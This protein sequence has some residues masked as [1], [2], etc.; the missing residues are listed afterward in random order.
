V[1]AWW[2]RLTAKKRAQ[3]NSLEV[4]EQPKDAWILW[5]DTAS[6][7]EANN[8]Q[9]YQS[10]LTL[11]GFSPRPVK[12]DEFLAAP[13][14][15][16]TV[17]VVPDAAGARLRE[18][19]QK[20]I[21]KYVSSGGA[22]LADGRQKWLS[23]VG[24]Q[25]TGWHLPVA[26]M[27]ES[28][29]EGASFSWQPEE[30]TERYAPPPGSETLAVENDT[31]QS[32]AV[33]GRYG[34]GRYLYLSVP[35]DNHTPDAVSHYPYIREYLAHAFNLRSELRG[36]RIETYFDPGYRGGVNPDNLAT[37]W[38]QAGI[39]TVYVAAWQFY[40]RYAFNYAALIRACHRNG[41]SVCAWFMFPQVTPLMWQ[42]HPEWREQAAA[43]GDQ[44]P[45]PLRDSK[46]VRPE[47]NLQR[48]WNLPF[49]H[50]LCRRVG[51]IPRTPR[52]TQSQ[53]PPA[54]RCSKHSS[55]RR[56]SFPIR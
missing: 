4:Y 34:S 35:L 38:K 3:A 36:G 46:L 19:Q 28:L 56:S 7:A 43:G 26:E 27:K 15:K 20:E 25:M 1:Q 44:I 55:T 40:D 29:I 12:L 9:S 37:F 8:Q 51:G 41:I 48:S 32:I 14:D 45:A 49:A 50:A 31:K 11:S 53:P 13:R 5:L 47:G 33:A 16:R 22:V 42:Q 21:L 10:A 18:A 2:K 54:S 52:R 23:V 39:R 24:F 30:L 6:A 17:L